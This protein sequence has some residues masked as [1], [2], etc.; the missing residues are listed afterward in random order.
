[1]MW[2]SINVGLLGPKSLNLAKL[3]EEGPWS[4]IHAALGFEIDSES[5][6][7]T[8]PEAKI[9]SD[10]VL[11]DHLEENNGSRALEVATL[12]KIRGHV[13]LFRESNVM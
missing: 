10:R 2:G 7:I 9:A 3:E 4:N 12:Q 8:F 13:E 11:F 6:P 1:M 5:I